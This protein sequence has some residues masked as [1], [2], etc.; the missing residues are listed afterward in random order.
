MT[1]SRVVPVREA[2][3]AACL[4]ALMFAAAPAHADKASADACA[5]S[6]SADGKAIYAA[7]IGQV[8]SGAD[9]RETVTSTTKSLAM[10]GQI[11]RGSAR[12]NAEA[13]GACLAQAGS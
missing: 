2:L 7:A 8:S 10:S 3:A 9:V 5:A 1:L 6:L 11:S 13:A 4:G 12:S